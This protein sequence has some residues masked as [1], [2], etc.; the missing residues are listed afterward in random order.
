VRCQ[1][2]HVA[3]LI[4]G[5]LGRK[6]PFLTTD[7]ESCPASLPMMASRGDHGERS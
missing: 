2:I 1:N 7:L 5:E 4:F 6:S 3:R